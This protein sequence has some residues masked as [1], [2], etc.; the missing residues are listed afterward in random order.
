MCFL[1]RFLWKC[2]FAKL[3]LKVSYSYSF[4]FDRLQKI[5]IFFFFFFLWEN[6]WKSVRNYM[7]VI[8]D[9]L[10]YVKKNLKID[11]M[12]NLS[13]LCQLQ[14]LKI[15]LCNLFPALLE[16]ITY[17][18]LTSHCQ[19]GD[20]I[21]PLYISS[22][23]KKKQKKKKKKKTLFSFKLQC[24]IDFYTNL[25]LH[26]KFNFTFPNCLLHSRPFQFH[27]KATQ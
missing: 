15:G 12:S 6:V 18:S 5:Q 4:G 11:K 17:S 14:Y 7:E 9:I 8:E 10:R 26:F 13:L 22:K 19:S 16:C 3:A 25:V 23:N 1:K 20:Q 24:H 27:Q 21:L 2:D